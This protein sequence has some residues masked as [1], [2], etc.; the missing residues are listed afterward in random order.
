MAPE[1]RADTLGVGERDIVGLPHIIE[2]EQLD[3]HVV[4]AV[5]TGLEEGEAVVARIDVEEKRLERLEDVIA[6][7]EAKHVTI[8]RNDIVEP[9]DR[10][11]CVAHAKRA[12]AKAR[13]RAAWPERLTRDLS[14]VKDFEPIADGV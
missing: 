2:A 7:A 10:K 4:D 12:G 3:H 11:H 13:N 1:G 14:T 9:L 6:Q 5:L 8:E